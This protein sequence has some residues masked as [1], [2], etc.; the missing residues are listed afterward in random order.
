MAEAAKLILGTRPFLVAALGP[1]QFALD[2]SFEKLPAG[3]LE[4][5]PKKIIETA[6]KAI[7]HWGVSTIT[8]ISDQLET[9]YKNYAGRLVN[10]SVIRA[11]LMTREDFCWLDEAGGWFWLS[12]LPRNRVLNQIEKIL[13]VDE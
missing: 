12:S 6:R 9:Q 3:W 4:K 8:N 11:I 10:D 1:H 13:S 5:F 2:A 7:E